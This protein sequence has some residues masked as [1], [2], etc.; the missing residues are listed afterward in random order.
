MLGNHQRPSVLRHLIISA[1]QCALISV[2][3]TLSRDSIFHLHKGSDH[4][5]IYQIAHLPDSAMPPPTRVRYS[6]TTLYGR[7]KNFVARVQATTGEGT[8]VRAPCDLERPSS[9]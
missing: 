6:G 9:S 4:S 3:C 7:A 8:H 2:A 1:R 5:N